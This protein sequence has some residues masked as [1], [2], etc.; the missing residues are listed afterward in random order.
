MGLLRWL[1]C[2][3]GVHR[4]WQTSDGNGIC[5]CGELVSWQRSPQLGWRKGQKWREWRKLCPNCQAA[6]RA[7]CVEC[8][9]KERG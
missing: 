9:K 7:V 3:F 6:G 5:S 2:F 1:G 8:L 4:V